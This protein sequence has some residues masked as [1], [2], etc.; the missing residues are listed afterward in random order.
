MPVIDHLLSIGRVRQAIWRLWYPFLTRRLRGEEVLFLNYAFETDPPMSLPLAPTDEPNRACIQLYHHVAT[1]V[2]LRGKDLLEVSCGH[3]GG[4]SYLARTLRPARYT[5]LDLNPAGVR[6]CAKRHQ[7][8]GLAFVQ[9]DAENLPFADDA[10]DAVTISFGLRNVADV[11]AALA[12]MRRVARHGGRLLI[13]EFSHPTWQPWRSL[14]TNYLMRAL[15]PVARRVSS[16]PDSYV[17]LAESIR[18]WPNQ[19]ALA[20]Q[21][22]TAGW[23]QVEFRNLTGGIVALHRAVKG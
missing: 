21:I 5:G 10:F 1:Q 2:E 23:E 14:Y 9:G 15:P 22:V 6:F 20:G 4:A 8:D 12:E 13:C 18:A 11:D 16:S 3:G 19:R 7:V 17:Y